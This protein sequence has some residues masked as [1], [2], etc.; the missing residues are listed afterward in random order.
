MNY[1]ALVQKTVRKSAAKVDVP[2]TVIGQSGL[3]E[4]FVEWVQEAW[5][6]IQ[7][8]RLGIGWRVVTGETLSLVAGTYEY[9]LDTDLESVNTRTVT[10]HLA[11]ENET[12]VIFRTSDYYRTIIDRVSRSSGPPQYFTLMP[13]D[14]AWVFWPNPD[15]AY[16]VRFEGIRAIQEFDYTD[17][18]GVG[19]SDVLTPTGLDSIYHDAIVWQAVANYAMHF[20]DG[21]KLQE[22][23]VKF[24]PYKKYF[25]ERFMDIPTVDTSAL[26]QL[27]MYP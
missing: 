21:S 7:M 1:L 11:G 8:E 26:Y 10:Q 15:Q 16:T 27:R 18:A 24:R 3:S 13:D 17:A 19:S 22:A 9:A 20:E 6:E 4:L 23:Q 2:T 14:K 5:K 12:P 25:E